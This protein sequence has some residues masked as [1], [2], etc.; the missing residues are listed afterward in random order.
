MPLDSKT[1]QMEGWVSQ[2]ESVSQIANDMAH[3]T[4]KQE[5][6]KWK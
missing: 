1:K 3:E 5:M 4:E 2:N 6:D